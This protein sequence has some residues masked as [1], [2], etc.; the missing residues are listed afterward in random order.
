MLGGAGER[1]NKYIE[2]RVIHKLINHIKSIPPVASYH[3]NS[4]KNF[5][6][7]INVLAKLDSGAT[8]HFL[9]KNDGNKL[10]II[11]NLQ[12]AQNVLLPDNLIVQLTKDGIL[13]LNNSL[14]E[15]TCE[16]L[17]F[18]N[19][20]N[21]SLIFVGQLCDDKCLV[22]FTKN[23][24]FVMKQ[25]KIIHHGYH[26]KLD[27]LWNFNIPLKHTNQSSLQMNYT[28]IR[29]KT[30]QDLARYFHVCLFSPSIST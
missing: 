3:F 29:D 6:S 5:L 22:L 24:F 12:S 4:D 21:S 16:A 19:I 27:G 1:L 11:K 15:T 23:N 18:P 2:N 9:T 14:R 13:P 20:T 17:I 28:I 8:K 10:E 7:T 25:N 26:N 30:Q